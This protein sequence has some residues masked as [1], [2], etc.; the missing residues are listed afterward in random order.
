MVQISIFSSGRGSNYSG[1][2]QHTYYRLSYAYNAR[3]DIASVHYKVKRQT[4]HISKFLCI[5]LVLDLE[6][7]SI[8]LVLNEQIESLYCSS[9]LSPRLRVVSGTWQ[10]FNKYE[11]NQWWQ[12]FCVATR[13]IVGIGKILVDFITTSWKLKKNVKCVNIVHI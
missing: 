9:L 2:L 12:N 10:M 11:V 5:L 13:P 8:P 1:L 6:N 7:S 3:S 4:E